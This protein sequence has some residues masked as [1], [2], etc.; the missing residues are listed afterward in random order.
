MV[1]E[2]EER[3]VGF[4]IYELHKNR[5]HIL[6]FAV[7][8]QFRRRNVGAQMVGKLF[9][10]LG[11]HYQERPG[12]YLRILKCG[13]RD[14]DNAPMAYVQLVDRPLL[15]ENESTNSED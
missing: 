1:A 8:E 7:N 11:P 10:D 4:M 15:D 13:F 3:V 14:G 6:N 12:G 5:L 9:D 2:H